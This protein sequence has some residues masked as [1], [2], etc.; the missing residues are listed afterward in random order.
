MHPLISV[1]TIVDAI[2]VIIYS[3]Y[4]WNIDIFCNIILKLIYF[5]LA[6]Q[7]DRKSVA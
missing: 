4:S 7:I 2:W 1:N 6:V 5:F 3:I